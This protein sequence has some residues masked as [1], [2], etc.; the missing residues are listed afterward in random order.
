LEANVEG[1]R[2]HVEQSGDRQPL[3]LING[4]GAHVGMCSPL[5]GAPMSAGVRAFWT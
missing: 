5:Q 2:I 4:I 3:L 1:I